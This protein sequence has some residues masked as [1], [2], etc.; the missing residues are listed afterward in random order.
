MTQASY[1][2]GAAREAPRP[3]TGWGWVLAAGIS[4]ILLGI[5]ALV[6]P[7]LTTLATAI[8]L[9]AMLLVAGTL[10]LVGGLSQIR[11]RGGW[12]IALLG[13]LSLV[14]GIALAFDPFAGAV[15]LVWA[16]GTW[17]FVGGIFELGG[18]FALPPGSS[19]VPLFLV[20]LVDV[21]LGLLIAFME[22]ASA[23]Y[24]LS[25]FVS[26]SLVARGG[27]AIVHAL[28]LRRLSRP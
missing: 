17:I 18:A 25:W 1:M 4:F 8:Y 11:D 26:L 13:L 16:I 5:A 23:I 20:A 28:E 3:T 2:S 19:R 9:G 10:A 27:W 21:A 7:K 15:S 14:A 22:P 12:L 6:E 24:F